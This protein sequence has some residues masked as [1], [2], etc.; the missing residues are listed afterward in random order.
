MKI[1]KIVG[2]VIV[3][4]F[5]LVIIL[6]IITPGDYIAERRMIIN[7][8]KELVFHHVQYWRNWQ[9]W[10]P[11]AE[12]DATMKIK[13]DGTD[14]EVGS[15]YSWVG[16][17]DK[18]GSGEMKT[19]GLTANTELLYEL[20]FIE[21]WENY[22][23]GWMRLKTTDGE[24][25]EAAWGFQGEIPFPWNIMLMFTS[26]ETMMT[27][28]FDRGLMM[29]KEI[30]EK[31]FNMIN[32]Y[33]VEV[34]NYPNKIYAT[35]RQVTEIDNLKNFFSQSYA[36]IVSAIEMNRVKKTGMP[37]ALYYDWDEQHSKTDVAAAIPVNRKF[38]SKITKIIEFPTRQA[39]KVNY[40][41]PYE[42]LAGAHM[43]LTV[44]FEQNG[45]EMSA[46]VIEEYTTDPQSQ[47]DP[48]KWLTVIYYFAEQ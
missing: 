25:T 27:P 35:I 7:A 33:N 40:Y 20:H 5:V 36:S 34:I 48:S 19:T 37:C 47:P 12:Q 9:A 2:I 22:A 13:V 16:D 28:D 43:A 18:T 4:I 42:G 45:L 26:M 21:P 30:S 38:E 6:G 1:L 29:L 39:Y 32:K 10:S 31:E 41:G 46:P 15:V 24:K 11:W 23:D 44:Y 17:P 8:P 14:G 3:V